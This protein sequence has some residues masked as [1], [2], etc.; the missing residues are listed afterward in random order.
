MKQQT[1]T[2]D[3]T[4]IAQARAQ[5]FL[6][7]GLAANED[8]AFDMAITDTDVM[9]WEFEDFLSQLDDILACIS[10]E[11]QYYVAGRNMGWRHL[12]GHAVVEARNAESF[13]AKAFPKTTEWALQGVFDPAR[14]VL[15]FRLFHHDAPTGEC[16][17]VSQ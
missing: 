16:Y 1:I 11:G 4:Q 17:S 5:E 6:E 15:E 9:Q 7:A 13:I 2:W 10:P 14:K 8:E 3:E 12:S